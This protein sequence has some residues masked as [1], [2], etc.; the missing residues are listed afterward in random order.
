MGEINLAKAIQRSEGME[1]YDGHAKNLLTYKELMSVILQAV[2]HE[3][4]GMSIEEIKESIDVDAEISTGRVP[5]ESE[6][7]VFPWGGIVRYDIK[8]T[9]HIQKYGNL[10][11]YV[12]L[13]AQKN[14]Y[15]GYD[16]VTRGICYGTTLLSGQLEKEVSQG[17]YDNLKKV[18]SI[19][20][21]LN[22]PE[23]DANTITEYRI[24]PK[25]IYG[26]PSKY[27]RYDLMSVLMIRLPNHEPEGKTQD[28][29]EKMLAALYT[30]FKAEKTPEEKCKDLKNRYGIG[31]STEFENEVRT[32]CNFSE[33]ILERGI[34][35]GIER[36]IEQGRTA[37]KEQAIVNMLDLGLSKERIAEKYPIELIEKVM[38][39][40]RKG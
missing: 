36:G 3:F 12:N 39:E 2:V 33:A 29:V 40:I 8:F 26:K 27:G 21:C 1:Q 31:I 37:E 6:E 17:D 32:M 4:Q 7:E 9:V 38:Q 23:K 11:L 5:G 24:E 28:P 16:L 13:E 22:A 35:Q 30:I 19:W 20:I 14:Y 25:T 34:E 18:Y 10:K 15:P